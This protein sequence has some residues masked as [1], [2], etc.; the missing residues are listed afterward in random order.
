MTQDIQ[1][2]KTADSAT[3]QIDQL[4][5]DDAT[6]MGL[7]DLINKLEPLIAGGRLNRLVDLAS[8]AADLVDMSDEYMIEKMAKAGEELVG[9]VWSTG[10]A[11]RMAGAQVADMAETPTMMGLVRMAREPEVRRGLAFLLAFAGVLGKQYSH[12]PLNY[13]ED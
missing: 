7:Q 4:L 3:Q 6:L 1:P 12:Q 11:A 5:H 2:E 8:V 9:G 10:N 13:D